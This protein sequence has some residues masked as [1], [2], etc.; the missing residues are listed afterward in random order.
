MSDD[1]AIMFNAYNNNPDLLGLELQALF[2]PIL[3]ATNNEVLIRKASRH[4]DLIEL[5]VCLCG[6]RVVETNEIGSV[7]RDE[8][9]MECLDKLAGHLARSVLMYARQQP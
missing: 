2:Q 5:I 6:K 7:T 4:D 1:R 3:S 9:V 8:V